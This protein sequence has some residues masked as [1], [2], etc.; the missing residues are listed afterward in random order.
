MSIAQIF[1]NANDNDYCLRK[2]AID[3]TTLSAGGPE[4]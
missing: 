3:D 2:S 1:V 4:L